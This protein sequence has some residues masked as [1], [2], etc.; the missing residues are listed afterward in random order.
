MITETS[1]A[2]FAL[3]G[4]NTKIPFA[5]AVNPPAVA[6]PVVHPIY[7]S[8]RW[9]GALWVGLERARVVAI[10]GVS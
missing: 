3:S 6:Y 7:P 8:A 9:L 1:Q 4:Y 2:Q 10:F 5:V